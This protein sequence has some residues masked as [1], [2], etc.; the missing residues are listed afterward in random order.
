MSLRQVQRIARPTTVEEAWAIRR[1]APDASRFLAGGVDLV[2]YAPP[3]V[4]TL[5][6]LSRLGLDEIREEGDDLV[7]GAMATL[8]QALESPLVAGSAGGFLRDVLRR[9]ASPLQRNLATIGG[10]AVRGHPWSDVVTALLVLDAQLDAYDGRE[11]S[12][13]LEEAGAADGPSP[14]VRAIRIPAAWRGSRAAF[15]KFSRAAVDVAMLNCACSAL[16]DRGTCLEV[17][18]AVGGT[19]ALARR[20]PDVER[21]LAGTKLTAVETRA[22]AEAAA[23]R[24]E[25]RDDLRASAAY[26]RRL[27]RV[28][29]Q[30]CLE[31]V[32]GRG[33]EKR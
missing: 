22:A 27:A 1:A 31:S 2:L 28:G 33:E 24:I 8:S 13:S 10:A 7:I 11:A 14:L 16:V 30:R 23:R 32:A 4:T 6:D 17:R 25:A 5:I 12:F 20:L 3:S 26:R 15:E 21:S 9:V 29:V 19:P 18:V